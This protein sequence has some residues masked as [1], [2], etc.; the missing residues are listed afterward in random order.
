M[1]LN[2]ELK[3][4]ILEKQAKMILFIVANRETGEGW[5]GLKNR[6]WILLCVTW[7]DSLCSGYIPAEGN[8]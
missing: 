1:A 6:S 8:L 7:S 4:L 3:E 5:V 2:F